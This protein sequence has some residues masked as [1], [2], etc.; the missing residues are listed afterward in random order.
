MA[1]TIDQLLKGWGSAKNVRDTHDGDYDD[2]YAYCYPANDAPD[3]QNA[4]IAI[5]QQLSTVLAGSLS[6]STVSQSSPWFALTT[7]DEDN[8]EYFNE[9]SHAL[10]KELNASNFLLE[11]LDALLHFVV[12]GNL[13]IHMTNDG[14]DLVFKSCDPRN[15]WWQ[16][17]MRGDPT[18]VY[19]SQMM[20]PLQII[21]EFPE[22]NIPQD[23]KT[24]AESF[25]STTLEVL[26]VTYR[27]KEIATPDRLVKPTE[28]PYAS[29]WILVDQ[30][31]LLDESGYMVAPYYI[32][33][34]YRTSDQYGSGP[35]IVA[36]G[37]LRT[38]ALGEEYTLNGIELLLQPPIFMPPNGAYDQEVDLS[39]GA[40]NYVDFQNGT[41]VPYQVN[42]AGVEAGYR[43][44]VEKA[45]V[46]KGIF[47]VNFFLT[48]QGE[49]Q[50]Q[51]ITA[52]EA[53]QRIKEQARVML[54][55]LNRLES[56]LFSKMIVNAY[57]LLTYYG[58][59]QMQPDASMTGLMFNVE[60]TSGASA[61]YARFEE[62]EMMSLI[63][64]FAQVSQ[65]LSQLPAIGD[66]IDQDKLFRSMLNSRQLP[67][68]VI[69]T[70][71]EVAE[72]RAIRAEAEAQ[73]MQQQAMQQAVA[74]VDPLK[75][76][77]DGSL[78]DAMPSD[79]LATEQMPAPVME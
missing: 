25:D 72:L 46:L 68:D 55:I 52:T 19:R 18:V 65:I 9:V 11:Y 26:H 39:A 42:P 43:M 22:A 66:N 21:D 8:Q 47:F 28:M 74:P 76:P 48:I 53:A 60:F 2:A 20:T 78:V 56:D 62:A 35:G 40:V 50:A 10:H 12:S 30:K 36:L 44:G 41:P 49:N 32:S 61:L 23:I 29:V 69:R 59:P 79:L 16:Q 31:H 45:E 27:R 71:Q 64:E 54:G 7:D 33:K 14:T 24:K 75:A 6:S 38:V 17:D 51:P 77:E 5:G 63:A 4:A 58:Q 15:V 13:V 3:N 67:P 37:D 34:F 73:M 57:L 1:K 70:E